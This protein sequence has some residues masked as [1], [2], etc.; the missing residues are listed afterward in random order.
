[1]AQA[2]IISMIVSASYFEIID[3]PQWTWIIKKQ[4]LQ[5]FEMSHHYTKCKL[6]LRKTCPYS[7][8][9][10]SVFSRIRT[11][12]GEIGSISPYS[13]RM[14][15]N[16]DQKNSNYEH[17]LRSVQQRLCSATFVQKISLKLS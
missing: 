3:L 17:F 9:F 10:W 15:E 14:L 6:P 7:E 12:Y 1:M 8:F 5:K 4:L 2:A 16:T 11:E 13:V